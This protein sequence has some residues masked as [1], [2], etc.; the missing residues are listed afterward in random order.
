MVGVDE[1]GLGV[2]PFVRGRLL[3]SWFS[4]DSCDDDDES[5]DAVR[6]GARVD[7]FSRCIWIARLLHTHYMYDVQFVTV[8]Q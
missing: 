4:D 8:I 3:L 5:L 2:E 1:V 6:L 7:M